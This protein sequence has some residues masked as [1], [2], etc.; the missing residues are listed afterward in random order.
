MLIIDDQQS[1]RTT[2]EYVL[3]FSGYHVIGADSGAGAIAVAATEPIDGALIDVHM[4]VMNGFET[5]LRLQAQASALGRMFRIWFMTG[6]PSKAVERRAIELGTFGVLS[7]PFDLAA[8]SA[9]LEAGFSSPLPSVLQT[10]GANGGSDAA[11]N[12]PP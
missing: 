3:G 1:V 8:L 10:T 11:T 7:K 4:P 2:L 6:A 12:L 5:C 9:R